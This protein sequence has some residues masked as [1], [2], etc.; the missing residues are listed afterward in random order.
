MSERANQLA[1]SERVAERRADTA[2]APA[3]PYRRPMPIFWWVRRR[4]Y[5]L[6]VAREVSSVFVAWFVVFLLLMVRALGQ[7]ESAYQRFVDW[8][9]NP[10]VLTVNIVALAFVV[11]HAV[12][13]FN[14]AP[15]AMVLKLRGRTVPANLVAAA[16]F[17]AWIVVSAVVAV[18][19]YG[20]P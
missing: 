2:S 19:V 5:L 17:G 18:I 14:L 4:S 3:R 16:H 11:L 10:I 7:G 1:Q 8:S 15:K 20:L 12:T 13:W 9:A 6:F